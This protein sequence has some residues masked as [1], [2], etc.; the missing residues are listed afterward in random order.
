[1][2]FST[3]SVLSRSLSVLFRNLVPFLVIAVAVYI[4]VFVVGVIMGSGAT[5]EKG[6]TTAILTVGLLGMLM[7]Y[8]VAGAVAY[9]VFQDLRGKPA[10]IGDCMSVGFSRMFPVLG[11]AFL[12]GL[13]V[14][15][16]FILLVIPGILLACML[17]VA[18]AVVEKP[19]VTASLSR[20]AALTKGAR[21]SIFAIVLVIGVLNNVISRILGGAIEATDA[22]VVILI[23][24]VIALVFNLWGSVAQAVAYY[25]LRK[26]KEGV[27]I[28]DLVKVFE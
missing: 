25:D 14:I 10:S 16:G 17:Y 8:L 19:G 15:G 4:P 6:F 13:A 22:V 26:A 24:V 23:S 1:M 28:E 27:D 2:E 21:W 5:T 9:G 12:A 3:G 20:S 18:V 7:S 11:V